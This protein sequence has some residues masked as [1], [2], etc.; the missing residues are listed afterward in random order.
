MRAECGGLRAEDRGMRCS[1]S[2]ARSLPPS[3]LSTP[4]PMLLE[5]GASPVVIFG[6]NEEFDRRH[7]DAGETALE[8]AGDFAFD[9]F[10]LQSDEENLC[11]IPIARRIDFHR[12]IGFHRVSPSNR[13]LT[14]QPINLLYRAGVSSVSRKMPTSSPDSRM[15]ASGLSI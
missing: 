5:I 13:C 9:A 15:L 8:F 10:V 6:T 2:S 4:R 3:A 14:I 12:F 7:S 11:L 1:F